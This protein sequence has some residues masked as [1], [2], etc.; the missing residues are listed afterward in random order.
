[1][2]R[3]K[4]GKTIWFIV[5]QASASHSMI[6]ACRL[7]ICVSPSAR[8]GGSY[9]CENTIRQK[10]RGL[11]ELP[12]AWTSLVGACLPSTLLITVSIL[13]LFRLLSSPFQVNLRKNVPPPRLSPKRSKPRWGAW[14]CNI[15]LGSTVILVSNIPWYKPLRCYTTRVNT[16]AQTGELWPS[17][18]LDPRRVRYTK[19]L[20]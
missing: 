13:Y 2:L 15:L 7:A 1:M 11:W 17:I 12:P 16:D 9:F 8:Q 5:W 4:I 10:S 3:K 18:I 6:H 20:W 19:G 14:R